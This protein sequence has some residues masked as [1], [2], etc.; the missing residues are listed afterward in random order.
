MWSSPSGPRR[1]TAGFQRALRLAD[2]L[3]GIELGNTT[4]AQHVLGGEVDIAGRVLV[5][6]DVDD[7]RGIGTAMFLQE[8]GCTRDDRHRRAGR[9]RG[10]CTTVPP[11][12]RPVAGLPSPAA[13]WHRTRSS[14]SGTATRR[15]CVR[16]SP[17]RETQQRFD[18]LVVAGTPVARVELSAELERLGVTHTLVGDCLAPR[19]AAAAI[20]DGRRVA[21]AI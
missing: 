17:A 4:T 16:R 15:R 11:T 13:S 18:W 3:P 8:R 6:D 7:W 5:L 9:R 1:P 2:Q 19:T 21:L 14:S 10:R 20:L 12:S